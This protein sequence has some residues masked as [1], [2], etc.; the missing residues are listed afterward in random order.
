MKIPHLIGI[1]VTCFIAGIFAS[2]MVLAVMFTV[3][4]LIVR[5]YDYDLASE[6]RE[7]WITVGLGTLGVIGGAFVVWGWWHLL[8]VLVLV[9]LAYIAF[10]MGF[11][12]KQR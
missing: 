4:Y 10:R 3:T 1:G 12:T 2:Y 9:L 11:I 6:R 5:Q 7:V 8:S